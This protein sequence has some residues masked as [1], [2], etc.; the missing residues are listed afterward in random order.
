MSSRER[1]TSQPWPHLAPLTLPTAPTEALTASSLASFG[2]WETS[3]SP[4]DKAYR[5]GSHGDPGRTVDGPP[6]QA[7][8][9]NAS[10]DQH[11]GMLPPDAS[12]PL[13]VSQVAGPTSTAAPSP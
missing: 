11:N 9:L 5:I 6:S 3:A 1:T 10:P 8:A 7:R 12:I 2:A 4:A 13:W